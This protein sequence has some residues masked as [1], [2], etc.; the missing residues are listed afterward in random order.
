MYL[1]LHDNV[2][3][4]KSSIPVTWE[5]GL[6]N[7]IFFFII[8]ETHGNPN[9]DGESSRRYCQNVFF[10]S[11]ILSSFCGYE[12]KTYTFPYGRIFPFNPCDFDE[13]REE[14]QYLANPIIVDLEQQFGYKSEDTKVFRMGI[15]VSKKVEWYEFLCYL[16]RNMMSAFLVFIDIHAFDINQAKIEVEKY[17]FDLFLGE[18]ELLKELIRLSPILDCSTI[19]IPNEWVR[20]STL[21]KYRIRMSSPSCITEYVISYCVSAVIMIPWT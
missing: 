7:H 9:N 1:F 21:I 12:E 19:T 10:S 5:N 2:Q 13:T 4:S 11:L 18:E 16:V 14:F 3:N 8:E 20:E 17:H 6:E 15:V